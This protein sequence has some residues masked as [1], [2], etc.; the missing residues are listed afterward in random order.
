MLRKAGLLAQVIEAGNVYC[1]LLG[2]DT[3]V[4][5]PEVPWLGTLG[6]ESSS[7]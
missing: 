1:L 4:S 2:S 5:G 7:V 3:T 6:R